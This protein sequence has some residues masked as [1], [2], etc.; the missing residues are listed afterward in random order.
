MY[1]SRLIFRPYS[2]VIVSGL[3]CLIFTSCEDTVQQSSQW[4]ETAAYPTGIAIHPEENLLGV[5]S[6]NYDLANPT[7][8]FSMA[9]LDDVADQLDDVLVAEGPLGS[10]PEPYFQSVSIP[11]F[12]HRPVYSPSGEQ[13]FVATRGDNLIAEIEMAIGSGNSVEL[14]CG[15]IDEDTDVLFCEDENYQLRVPATD[16]YDLVLFEQEDNLVK[17]AVA[18]ISHDEVLFFESDT[19]AAPEARN[20]ITGALSLGLNILG[21]RSMVY[22]AETN[23]SSGLLFAAVESYGYTST[24]PLIS[25]V[26]FDPTRGPSG[27]VR[28]FSLSDFTGSSSARALSLTHDETALVL[29]LRE[30]DALLRIHIED[31][32]GTVKLVPGYMVPTCRNPTSIAPFQLTDVSSSDASDFILVACYSDDSL[33]LYDAQSLTQLGAVRHFGRGPFDIAI[34]HH[35]SPPEAYVS[36]FLD[37][38][39][40]VFSLQDSSG[41]PALKPKGRLGQASPKPEDGR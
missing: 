4:V 35:V 31:T 39:V 22:R 29:A 33:M 38:S 14:S 18:L 40:G 11:S 25:I 19:S 28:A 10:I 32:G 7:G 24:K 34:N 15:E 37:N 9:N 26:Y 23:Q 30:P 12:G 13:I 27:V 36:Y 1:L 3:V 16:P 5:V 6:S 17:G 20:R 8:A 2:S 41:A 21:A